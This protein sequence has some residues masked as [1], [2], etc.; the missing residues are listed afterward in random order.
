MD[1][2]NRKI[3]RKKQMSVEYKN[4]KEYILLNFPRETI[5]TAY[6]IFGEKLQWNNCNGVEI[7][8]K[9]MQDSRVFNFLG[10]KMLF[11]FRAQMQSGKSKAILS[12]LTVIAKKNKNIDL[13]VIYYLCSSNTEL[14][15]Q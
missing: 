15:K 3:R 1:Y 13:N 5:R 8:D 9:I 11:D 7:A 14:L 4:E 12:A 6:G 2:R 10:H